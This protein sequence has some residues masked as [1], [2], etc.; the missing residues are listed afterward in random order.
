MSRRARRS[1]WGSVHEVSP[2]H[3]RV[4]YWG[5]DAQ[6]RYRR[7]SET[8]RGSRVDAERR[9]SE[10]MVSHSEDAPCPTVGEAWASWHLP[11]MERRVEG[12]DLS[13]RS[14]THALSA[15]SRHAGPRW[16]DV[17]CD[18]VRPLDVQQWLDRIPR[19]AALAAMSVLRPTLDHAV[20]YGVTATNPFRERYL[21]PSSSTVAAA[22][23][24]VW[25]LAELGTIWRD[26]AWG[27]WWEAA[28]L[29]L[30]FGGLRVGE[31]LGVS[32]SDCEPICG[33]CAAH[34]V[35][36]VPN[37]GNVPSE[38]LKTP[39]SVRVAPV[40]GR[41]GA[42]LLSIASEAASDGRGGWLSGDG[43][44]GPSSQARLNRAWSLALDAAGMERHPLRNLRNSFE[45][46]ARWGLG[47]PPWLLEPMIGH[48]GRGVTGA[49]YDRPSGD[50]LARAM[51]D[52]YAER[53]YDAE[54]E[55]ASIDTS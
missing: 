24:S 18:A 23:K 13:Q 2:G 16:A 8:V 10:L 47:L 7:M 42:R 46:N 40:P 35:R 49:Y 14:L 1:A 53:P 39:Q 55:W 51:A 11:T 29:L 45:T 34:V 3:W 54:W 9:R 38:R 32:S 36:Q 17:P 6:G 44:G 22:D 50:M 19:S 30:A 48:A 52:A 33:L 12:G 27:Q 26:V 20:R 41:A 37:R 31:A 43:L 5:A 21:M 25:S 4:R 15:W 28:F